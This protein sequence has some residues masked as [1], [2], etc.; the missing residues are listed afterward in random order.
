[1]GAILPDYATLQAMGFLNTAITEKQFNSSF[2][3]SRY[4]D[5]VRRQL[6]VVDEQEAIH[7]YLWE[8][9]PDGLNSEL[10]ERILY[11]R[12]KG[13]FFKLPELGG[14]A[15]FLPVALADSI[16]CYGRFKQ[17]KPLPFTGRAQ[18]SEDGKDE[19]LPGLSLDLIYD[20][21]K[22]RTENAGVLCY[23]YCLQMTQSNITRQALQ[24]PTIGILSQ[25]MAYVRTSL[26]GATG[27]RGVRV[28]DESEQ[29][30][31]AAAARGMETA[32]LC[33]ETLMP[34]VGKIDFQELMDGDA[35]KPDVL[36]MVYQALNNYR[37]SLYGLQNGGMYQKD[38]TYQNLN[39]S[40]MNTAAD[41]APLYDGLEQRKRAAET[42]NAAFGWS[43]R[44]SVNPQTIAQN[45]ATQ[46][47]T[48]GEGETEEKN[49]VM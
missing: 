11:Y 48:E 30:N 19:F 33:G 7:R 34:I 45:T 5:E 12:Y 46:T 1:M 4:A 21:P 37:R 8:D 39:E 22:E 49:D 6:R 17:G 41:A 16:D 35:S 36:L 13:V 28:G 18:A 29:S 44:V 47:P 31:V 2:T 26:K 38:T 10:I 24:E 9:L 25:I 20:I 14:R 23:D 27:V 32:A 40:Q 43:I 15:Y 42:A 3:N